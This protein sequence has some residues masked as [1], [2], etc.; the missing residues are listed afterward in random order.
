MIKKRPDALIITAGAG[1]STDCGLPDFKGSDRW[2][3]KLP[4]AKK[5]NL[6]YMD[7][8][9]PK[10]FYT[11]PEIGWG[12]YGARLQIYHDALPHQGYY[13]LLQF[14]KKMPLGYGVITSNV[15]T[16]FQRAGF[17]SG[18]IE[19]LHGSIVKAQCTYNC[20]EEIWD[21]HPFDFEFENDFAT[22]YP[23]C[24]KC[25]KAARPNILLFGDQG[26]NPS[27]ATKERFRINKWMNGIKGK[28]VLIVEIG[29]GMTVPTIRL[30]SQGLTEKL[31]ADFIRINQ[32]T[33]WA[34]KSTLR[35][36]SAVTE[37]KKMIAEFE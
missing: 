21:I 33:D 32:D 1:M 28:N 12:F 24:P 34:D 11:D 23:H 22:K 25:K 19:Q 9:D 5:L 6:K 31:D 13:D 18:K 4:I 8:V 26:W 29:A 2:E 17:S 37:I 30:T 7:L 16:L 15:D 3:N 14:A 36:G 27:K 35:Q 10:W 20:H